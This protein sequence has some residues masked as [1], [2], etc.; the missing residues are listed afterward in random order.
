MGLQSVEESPS[1]CFQEWWIKD[2]IKRTKLGPKFS[3]L[4]TWDE[5]FRMSTIEVAF[6]SLLRSLLRQSSDSILRKSCFK[7]PHSALMKEKLKPSHCSLSPKHYCNATLI[8]SALESLSKHEIRSKDIKGNWT[9]C[10]RCLGKSSLTIQLKKFNNLLILFGS[11]VKLWPFLWLPLWLILLL[12]LA[13]LWKN[14]IFLLSSLSQI[15]YNRNT[16]QL[17]N[18]SNSNENFKEL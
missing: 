2:Y 8:F 7:K 11:L 6:T 9:P 4:Q 3:G 13:I 10:K 5:T 14:F 15:C 12:T 16:I 17:H 1:F 18:E